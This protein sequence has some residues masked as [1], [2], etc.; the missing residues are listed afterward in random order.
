MRS[1]SPVELAQLLVQVGL[2]DTD[3][4]VGCSAAE[5]SEL[6][7][8]FSVALPAAYKQF[9]QVMGKQAGEFLVDASWLYP[10][11]SARQDAEEMLLSDQQ[12]KGKP[13]FEIS[14]LDFVF[15][16]SDSFF[17]FF[18]TES[19]SDDPVIFI[20]E[21]GAMQPK[22]FYSSFSEWLSTCAE[23]DAKTYKE[24]SDWKLKAH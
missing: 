18:R 5:I 14:A 23:H 13:T 24:H 1:K 8:R 4:I 6:E 11:N 17:L 10:L 3:K 2:A 9:L 22:K 16:C 20:Y 21:E 15:L 7:Q 12:R 19:V